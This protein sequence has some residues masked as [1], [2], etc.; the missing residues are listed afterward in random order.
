MKMGI[1]LPAARRGA[2]R[3]TGMGRPA[4]GNARLNEKER[5]STVGT[6]GARKGEGARFKAAF[7]GP[8]GRMN[9]NMKG[10]QP[11]GPKAK[12]SPTRANA[13]MP[14]WILTSCRAPT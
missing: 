6:K 4:W 9:L 2:R 1:E 10:V 3:I 12:H 14:S 13:L 5:P 11:I 8:G 7:P